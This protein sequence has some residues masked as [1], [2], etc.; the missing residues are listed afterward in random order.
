MKHKMATY[1]IWSTL[2]IRVKKAYNQ[3]ILIWNPSFILENG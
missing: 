2:D 1:I 3:P